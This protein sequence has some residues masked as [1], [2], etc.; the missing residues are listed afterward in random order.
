MKQCKLLDMKIAIF[1][2]GG[3]TASAAHE[4]TKSCREQKLQILAK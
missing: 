4:A 3:S 2:F 1:V